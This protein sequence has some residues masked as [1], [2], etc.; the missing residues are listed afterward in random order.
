MASPLYVPPSAEFNLV[1]MRG[2]GGDIAKVNSHE[3]EAHKKNGY[4][5]ISGGDP[6]RIGDT[7]TPDPDEAYQRAGNEAF[8]KAK[9]EGKSE[10]EAGKI[11]RKAAFEA[12]TVAWNAKKS[13]ESVEPREVGLNGD[14]QAIRDDQNQPPIG[15]VA[16][17][18]TGRAAPDQP[19]GW[20][21]GDPAK[22][23]KVGE[24]PQPWQVAGDQAFKAAIEAGKS[25][26]QAKAA[27]IKAA[28]KVEGHPFGD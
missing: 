27:A 5:P 8:A 19:V 20:F 13:S 10:E 6:I 25:V 17:N 16:N 22:L 26:A 1:I 9:A 18:E 21:D 4:K 24:V 2:P 23:A 7:G 3:V 28:K 14:T 15:R 11:A 12:K